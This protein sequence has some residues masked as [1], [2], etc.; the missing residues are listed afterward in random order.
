MSGSSVRLDMAQ[1]QPAE[2]DPNLTVVNVSYWTT[3]F[4]EVTRRLSAPRSLLGCV[5]IPVQDQRDR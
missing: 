5:G 2:F 1:V 4:C 3:R